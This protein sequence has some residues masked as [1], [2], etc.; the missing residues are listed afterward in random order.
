MLLADYG[1]SVIK[2]EKTG[3]IGGYPD[4]LGHGKKSIALNLKTRSGVEVFKK[5]SDRSDVIIDPFRRGVME[6]LNLG[7]QDL[8]A[9]NKSLIYA[10][11]TGFGQEGPYA[12]MAGHDINFLSLSGL[13]SLFGRQGEKP[14]PPVNLAADFGG[15][16]LMC[17]FAIVMALYERSQSQLGQVIDLSMTE[18]AAY[19]GTWLFR[20]QKVPGLW[21]NPRGKNILDTG[22]HFY[23][24]YET[25]DGKYM[26]IGALEP[27]FYNLLLEKL[28]VSDD[29]IPQYSEFEKNR[30]K[31]AALFKKKTKKEWSAIFHGTDACVTPVLSLKDASAN[32]HNRARESF[33]FSIDGTTTPNPAARLSRTPGS[34]MAHNINPMPGEHSREI[35]TEFGFSAKDIDDTIASGV[36]E[37]AKKRAKL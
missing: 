37:Q 17:A 28:G 19:L 25:E 2:V 4:V 9:R 1:A 21:G 10:R 13:L 35:L 20:S 26:A 36:V 12:D 15:G 34:S 7:P 29:E 22:A 8:M 30:E 14:T 23:D 5:L 11:L 16:G 18:G 24:T 27:Q 3:S 6:K 32:I 31:L 33:T